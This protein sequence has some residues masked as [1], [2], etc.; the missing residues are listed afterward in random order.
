MKKLVEG[1]PHYK[2]KLHD[3]FIWNNMNDIVNKV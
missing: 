3:E 2:D 1:F